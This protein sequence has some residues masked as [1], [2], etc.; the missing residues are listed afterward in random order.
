MHLNHAYNIYYHYAV[1]LL[2]ANVLSKLRDANIELQRSNKLL[3]AKN[4]RLFLKLKT[5]EKQTSPSVTKNLLRKD[6]DCRFYTGIEKCS[7]FHTLHDYVAPYV[8]R[9]WKGSCR[10]VSTKVKRPSKFGPG[11]KFCSTE[12]CL[13]VLM[14]MRLGLLNADL[15]RRFD[16]SPTLCSQIFHTWLTAMDSILGALVF[17]TDKEQILATKPQRY[18]HQIV[19]IIDCS[20]VF[21]ET[22]KNLDLQFATWSDYKHHNTSRVDAPMCIMVDLEM[23]SDRVF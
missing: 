4:N 13:L 9:R 20:E 14:R 3:K 10:I 19:S 12:E 11:R 17:W 2:L 22:P 16:I 15:A 7:V 8:K 1:I 18:R 5:G 23:F 21:I 6:R